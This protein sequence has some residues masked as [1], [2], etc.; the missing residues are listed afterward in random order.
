MA[1]DQPVYIQGN[2]NSIN[3]KPAAVL[4]DTI[5]VLSSAWSDASSSLSLASRVPT[6]TTVN[7]A[8]L[9]GTTSTG[10]LEGT[11]GQNLGGYN[12]GVENF[13]RL[14]E[15]WNGTV[16]L[17]YRGSF[18]S[19]FAPRHV[20]G[21]WINGAPQS[22]APNRNWDFDAELFQDPETFPPSSP[23]FVYLRQELFVRRFDL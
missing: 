13:L 5:N 21:A 1:S 18:V 7:A 11:A 19:L 23:N 17:T 4:G 10:G 16:T 22:T 6:A 20:A 12:G 14:H 9:A 3:K 15:N 8:L 2:Y